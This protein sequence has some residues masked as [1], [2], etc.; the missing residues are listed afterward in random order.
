MIDPTATVPVPIRCP[1]PPVDGEPRHPDGDSVDV[2][3]QFGYGDSLALAKK[4]VQYRVG[5]DKDQQAIVLPY[6]DAFLQHETLLELAIK[7]WT[8]VTES[9]EPLPVG[10]PTILMLPEDIGNVIAERINE[11]YEAS[12]ATVPNVS[13]GQ[14]PATSPETSPAAPNRATRRSR[15]PSIPRSA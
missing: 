8:I 2:R 9:G 6:T 3:S 12:K 15:K 5:L 14:S 10:L 1:C 13:G 4:S 7:S 11:L